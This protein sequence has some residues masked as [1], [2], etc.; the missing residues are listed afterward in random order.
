MHKVNVAWQN[1]ESRRLKVRSILIW[2]FGL[3]SILVNGQDI[4]STV[5][6]YVKGER[7]STVIPTQ[8]LLPANANAVFFALAPYKN[9]SSGRVRSNSYYLI[10]EI[11]MHS[12]V[13]TTRTQAVLKLLSAL[14]DHDNVSNVAEH[15]AD[16]NKVDFNTVAKDSLSAISTSI[17]KNVKLIRLM[18]YVEI[19]NQ[20]TNLQSLS[21]PGNA[22]QI[23]WAALLAL[24]RMGDSNASQDILKRVKKIGV[25][26]D[27]VYDLFPDL[28]YTRNADV[29]AFLIEALLSDTKN[30]E[31]A[32][33][34][35]GGKIPCAYRVMEMLAP[36][37]KDYPLTLDVSGD[38]NAKD[39]VAAL[40]T[41]RTWFKQHPNFVIIKDT[42]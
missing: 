11:G 38:V 37:I 26:D 20:I 14:H 39:Y 42:Y 5:S 27:V 16:F 23:R 1:A 25:N 22:P 21:Q 30:C 17:D 36:V 8:L 19:K 40:Q 9:D 29:Y 13:Q 3:S 18:G 4:K 33:A 28:V 7:P 24:S 12:K 6:A 15:L 2:L 10:H 41:V 34:E 35:H 32:D 31:S